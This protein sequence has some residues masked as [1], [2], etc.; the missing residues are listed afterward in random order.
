[1]TDGSIPTEYD[2]ATGV[3]PEGHVAISNT[4]EGLLTFAV[5]DGG[6]HIHLF[7]PHGHLHCLATG[8]PEHTEEWI[9]RLYALRN[10]AIEQ[11]VEGDG[12]DDP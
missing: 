9:R 5:A 4:E 10:V 1:M 2:T 8:T 12:G 7:C 6:V 3:F 11:R